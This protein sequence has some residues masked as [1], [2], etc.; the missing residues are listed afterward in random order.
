MTL[1][2]APGTR[3]AMIGV[4]YSSAPAITSSL[5]RSSS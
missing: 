4:A 5:M 2:W 1:R 3:E